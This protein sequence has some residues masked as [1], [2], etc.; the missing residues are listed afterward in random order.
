[1]TKI[2]FFDLETTGVEITKDRIVEI[3]C[4]KMNTDFTGVEAVKKY[5]FNPGINI[6][7]E[8]TAVH[9]ITNEMV[10]DEPKFASRA[11]GLKEY[12]SDCILAGYNII[13]FDVPLLA[14]EFARCGIDWPQKDQKMIDAYF[15]F[16]EKEKRDLTSAY[17]FY[18]G[19]ELEGAHA[20]D[21]DVNATAEV[22]RSMLS[23]YEDLGQMDLVQIHDF[24]QGQYPFV[25]LAGKIV[26]KDNT[27]VYS[28]GK[29]KF[30]SVID[31]P[32]YGH[33]M[34]GQDFPTNTKN[35][36]ISLIGKPPQ[37]RW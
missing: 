25:D 19:K 5:R 21:N 20:A 14:E 17:K 28:F 31:N 3:A 11:V 37:K 26:L 27:P 32:S 34:L 23:K 8:A 29:D 30:K 7:E 36:L 24:C 4:V 10:A 18:C 13:T 12:L 33:W 2:V 35:V 9:G 15:I 6:P 16:R 22:F 1:M